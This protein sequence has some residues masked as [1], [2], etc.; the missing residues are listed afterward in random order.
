MSRY[1]VDDLVQVLL[2]NSAVITKQKDLSWVAYGVDGTKTTVD[3][4]QTA[5]TEKCHLLHA[6]YPDL[7]RNVVER[8]DMTYTTVDED[9]VL[10][11]YPDGTRVTLQGSKGQFVCENAPYKLSGDYVT[12][13][14]KLGHATVVT[15]AVKNQTQIIL[16]NGT[17]ITRG[18]RD[19]GNNTVE[20]YVFVEQVRFKDAPLQRRLLTHE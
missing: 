2:P 9:K 19:S 13:I 10:V 4:S 3:A 20:S 12:T 17:V 8:D 6:T 5:N 15:G 7:K 18:T 16:P 1:L 14:E 11:Q